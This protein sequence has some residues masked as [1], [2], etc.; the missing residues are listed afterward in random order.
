M[1]M[2]SFFT[3]RMFLIVG[4]AVLL[5]LG[6]AG[7]AFLSSAS[8]YPSFYLDSGENVAHT[9]LGIIALAAVYVP[10]LNSALRPYYRWIVILV[11]VIA[12]FFAVYGLVVSGNAS[13]NTFGLANLENPFDNVL[14]FVVAAWAFWSAR[15]A[16]PMIA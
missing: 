6:L 12:L 5:I 13:P 4:G 10:G 14:H 8:A 1:S 2:A 15:S 16:E 7:F 9:G 3:L 11:G